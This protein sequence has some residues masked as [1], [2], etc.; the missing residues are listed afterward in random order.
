L[1]LSW[2]QSNDTPLQDLANNF[3]FGEFRHMWVMTENWSRPSG[4]S[5]AS[6]P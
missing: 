5:D 4:A 2:R 6:P 1:H 3:Q